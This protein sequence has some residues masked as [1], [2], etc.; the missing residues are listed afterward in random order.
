[1]ATSTELKALM[2]ESSNKS[3]E[4]KIKMLE[5]QKEYD[6][7][8]K[9]YAELANEFLRKKE[10]ENP[11]PVQPKEEKECNLERLHYSKHTTQT[12]G[13]ELKAGD[14]FWE[15]CWY[16]S[17][18]IDIFKVEK[19]TAKKV[20]YKEVYDR[21]RKINRYTPKGKNFEMNCYVWNMDNMEFSSNSKGKTKDKTEIFNKITNSMI[22]EDFDDYGN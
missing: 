5:L 16:S 21:N 6:E 20:F 9:R 15:K 13:S 10:E 2:T 12:I 8:Q 4:I 18:G 17:Y 11:R 1:M 3:K 14:C 19:I 7:E 22:T